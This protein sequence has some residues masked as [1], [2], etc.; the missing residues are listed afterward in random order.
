MKMI[1]ILFNK[2]KNLFH[3]HK[4]E[5]TTVPRIVSGIECGA[6]GARIFYQESY[7][8]LV[9]ICKCGKIIT[10]RVK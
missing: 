1:K 4:Y 6:D 8:E 10:K 7:T 3:R 9:K 2:I 5:E